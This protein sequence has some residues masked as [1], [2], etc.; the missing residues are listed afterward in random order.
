MKRKQKIV[1]AFLIIFISFVDIATAQK[2]H[3][4]HP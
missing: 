2:S 3:G 1:M 4:D